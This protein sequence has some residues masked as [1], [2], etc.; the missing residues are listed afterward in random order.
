M[1]KILK[2]IIIFAFAFLFFSVSNPVFAVNSDILEMW[3]FNTQANPNIGLV[4]SSELNFR[5][6]NSGYWSSTNPF[7]VQGDSSYKYRYNSNEGWDSSNLSVF[8][9]ASGFSVSLWEKGD[10]DSSGEV[11]YRIALKNYNNEQVASFVVGSAYHANNYVPGIQ[12]DMGGYSSHTTV[13]DKMIADHTDWHLWTFTFSTSKVKWYYDTTLMFEGNIA[14]APVSW[15]E[16]K[17]IWSDQEN[18]N[19]YIDDLVIWDKALN[20]EEINVIYNYGHSVGEE[21]FSLSPFEI[22]SP[23]Q[24]ETKIKESW[25]TVEGHCPTDGTNRVALTNDCSNFSNLDYTVDCVGGSFSSDFYYNG[26]SSWVVAVEADSVAGDCVDYDS[27]MDVV[28]INGIEVIEGYPDEWYFNYDYYND[29]DI[30]I[31]SPVFDMPALTLPLGST[32]TDMSFSFT[33]PHPLSPLLAFNI[34]QYDENGNL[35]NDAYHTK[36]LYEMADTNNYSVNLTA[37]SSPI[38]YVVQLFNDDSLVRQYPFGVFV[39]DLDLIINPDEYRYLF[40]RLVEKLKKKVVFNYYFAFYDGFYSLFN[41][42]PGQF[43]D[44]AL[45]ITFQAMSANGEYDLEIPVFLGSNSAVKT[46]ANGLRPYVTTFLWLLF[47][48]YVLVRVNHLFNSDD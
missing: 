39:S 40:P 9:P 46:F 6:Y 16:I 48:V 23:E 5:T 27:L 4:N 7:G 30:E 15:D 43:D 17:K 1:Q 35:L 34:K 31:V 26:V 28:S 13:Q 24:G 8:N 29:F 10:P 32:N 11:R 45:D 44:D 19:C 25:I 18:W 2:T 36:F 22:T 3:D 33:Y 38:H 41:T 20:S 37:S 42:S 14:N 12:A 21:S 47:A